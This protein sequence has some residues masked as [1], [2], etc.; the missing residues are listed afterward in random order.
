M[1]RGNKTGPNGQGAKTGRGAGYCGGNATPGFENPAPRRGGGFGRGR[2]GGGFGRG[3]G[4]GFGRGRRGGGFGFR[5][6]FQ[7]GTDEQ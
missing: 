5:N 6:R 1:P 2:C 4:A 3:Q 7:E